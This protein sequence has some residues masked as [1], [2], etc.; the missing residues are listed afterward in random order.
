MFALIYH[1]GPAIAQ[2]V[3]EFMVRLQTTSP[4]T[5]Q[6]GHVNISGTLIAG[7]MQ[8]DAIKIGSTST[9]GHVLT[10]DSN[11]NGSWQAPQSGGS[12]NPRVYYYATFDT[13]DQGSWS[14]DN[15]ANMFGGVWPSQWTDGNGTA[16]QMSDSGEVLRTLL[17]RKGILANNAM[18]CSDVIINNSSTNGRVFVCLMRI[19]NSTADAIDWTPQIRYSAYE[20]WSEKASCALNGNSVWNS[21]TGN[22]GNTSFPISIPPLATSTVIFAVPSGVAYW[23]GSS[24]ARRTQLGFYNDSLVLPA[25]L[26]FV[27]DFETVP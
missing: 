1:G 24:Y 21:G 7:A 5:P 20:A 10:A 19:K 27:D 18:L 25:G 14:H 22:S 8:T 12:S 13:Y 15:D 3:K 9:P 26:E 4:G 2:G 11:G 16:D 6:S 23:T 17:N